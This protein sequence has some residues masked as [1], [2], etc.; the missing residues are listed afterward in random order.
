M[1]RSARVDR[2]CAS[3][4]SFIHMI[5]I[6]MKYVVVLRAIIIHSTNRRDRIFSWLWMVCT[7]QLLDNPKKQ[8]LNAIKKRAAVS[9]CAIGRRKSK[10]AHHD[11]IVL[12]Q[13]TGFRPQKLTSLSLSAPAPSLSPPPASRQPCSPA[14]VQEQ[15][16]RP[17][18]SSLSTSRPPSSQQPQS[19]TGAAHPQC[20]PS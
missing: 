16:L 8:S 1:Q 5:K 3:K 7:D 18:P 4:E 2:W 17:I 6:N 12:N 14:P 10:H 20:A 19:P 15:R 11:S 13:A 9:V